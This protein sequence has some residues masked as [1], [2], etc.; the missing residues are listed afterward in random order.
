VGFFTWIENT[1][2]AEMVRVSAYGY[3]VMITLHSLGLAIMVGLSSVLSLR[4]LG[5]FS[6]I[7]YSSLQRLLKIAWVGFIINFLSGS[8]LFSANATQFIVDWVFDVKMVMVILGAILVGVMQNMIGAALATGNAEAA[9][10]ASL[11]VVASLTILAWAIGMTFGR[12]V[13]YLPP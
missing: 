11:K 6:A 3:P 7:P 5:L 10:G 1:S 9:A 8:S 2:L 13:P 4:V 12:M